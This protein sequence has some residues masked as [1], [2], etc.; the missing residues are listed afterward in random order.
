MKGFVD[1]VMRIAVEGKEEEIRTNI[2]E[3]HIK[4]ILHLYHVEC[5]G[6]RGIAKRLKKEYHVQKNKGTDLKT[7]KKI[8]KFFDPEDYLEK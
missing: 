7:I 8:V 3:E 2:S 6:F 1:H 4:V 5:V